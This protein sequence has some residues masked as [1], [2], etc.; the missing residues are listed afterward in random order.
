[1]APP[2][3]AG[4]IGSTTV[5]SD[6]SQKKQTSQEKKH[7]FMKGRQTEYAQ[8]TSHAQAQLCFSF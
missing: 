8:Q 3:K 6:E 2:I 1:V 7:V 4:N 5:E